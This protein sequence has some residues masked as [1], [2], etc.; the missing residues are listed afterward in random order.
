MFIT[1][2]Q[3]NKRLANPRNLSNRFRNASSNKNLEYIRK[4][5]Q[6]ASL[7]TWSPT[8]KAEEAQSFDETKESER[9]R[10][11]SAEIGLGIGGAPFS[12]EIE[13]RE[14]RRP[15]NCR[16]WLS[17]S[18]RTSIAAEYAEARLSGKSGETQQEIAERHGV[19]VSTVSDIANGKRR[20]EDSPRSVEQ[21]KV[22]A[23]LEEVRAR[24]VAK[25][26]G[27]LD[28]ITDEGVAAHNAKDISQICVNMAKVVQQTIPQVN[29]TPNIQLVVVTPEQRN[30]KYYNV[31]EINS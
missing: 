9:I 14:L 3:L 17:K 23:V 19:L 12:T 5:S 24:A 31:V 27:G 4:D 7:C 28:K 10:A 20:I 8:A 26:M 13:H 30:E 18:E 11:L 25:L 29:N 1:E 22:D 6:N 16:P 2:E 21:N 15:G